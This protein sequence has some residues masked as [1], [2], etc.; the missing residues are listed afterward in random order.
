MY[1]PRVSRQICSSSLVSNR[2]RGFKMNFSSYDK[3][4]NIIT[5]IYDDIEIQQNIYQDNKSSKL[6]NNL[7]NVVN[8][9]KCEDF[10]NFENDIPPNFL[11]IK[12]DY[13]KE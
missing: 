8:F 13:C 4:I 3:E 2:N 6:N 7:T 11:K 5:L 12:I 9:K 10:Y 1:A